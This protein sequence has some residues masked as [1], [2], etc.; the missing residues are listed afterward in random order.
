MSLPSK[1]CMVLVN[2]ALEI[3]QS[4]STV[5]EFISRYAWTIRKQITHDENHSCL[6]IWIQGPSPALRLSCRPAG[7]GWSM[8]MM[9][10]DFTLQTEKNKLLRNDSEWVETST[11]TSMQNPSLHLAK[12]ILTWAI[13]YAKALVW[14]TVWLHCP[15]CRWSFWLLWFQME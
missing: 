3:H 5:S 12:S 9:W 11:H 15:L 14:H 7:R 6:S 1:T 4:I 13:C 8:W 10:M 2:M